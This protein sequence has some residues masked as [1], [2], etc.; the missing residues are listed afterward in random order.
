MDYSERPLIFAHRGASHDAPENTMAAFLLAAELGADGIEFDVQLARDGEV[1]V[2][3]DFSLEST[4]DGHGRVAN[5][6]LDELKRLDAGSWLGPES[7]GQ[8]IPTL[9]EVVE[10][11]GH[12]LLLNIE[13]KTTSLRAKDLVAEVVRSVE[14]HNLLDRVVVSSFNHLVLWQVGRLNPAIQLGLLYAP[15]APLSSRT[16]WARHLVRP[17]ALH[18]HYSIVND[19]YVRWARQHGYRIHTWTVNDPDDA[20]DLTRWGVDIIITDR[21]DVIAAAVHAGSG[22]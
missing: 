18:P 11:V 14:D 9:Q 15:D 4:T 17:D 6:A 22:Q 13:L 2:I 8:R 12:R 16:A 20:Q 21:P 7:A 19:E 5:K 1:V 3:H 10:G